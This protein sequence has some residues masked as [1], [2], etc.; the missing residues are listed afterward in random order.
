[1]KLTRHFSLIIIAT[2]AL[3]NQLAGV[4]P[5]SLSA[6]TSLHCPGCPDS[7]MEVSRHWVLKDCAVIDVQ[8]LGAF[9]AE[10]RLSEPPLGGHGAGSSLVLMAHRTMNAASLQLTHSLGLCPFSAPSV[11]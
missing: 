10:L 11:S 7:Q 6:V 3:F 9:E 5:L 4:D 8:S 2:L 1:M